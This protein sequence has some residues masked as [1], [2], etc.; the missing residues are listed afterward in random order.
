MDYRERRSHARG[1][2]PTQYTSRMG[3]VKVKQEVRADIR[4]MQESS[5]KSAWKK[6]T[7]VRRGEA[8]DKI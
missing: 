5:M 6:G 8:P 1:V 2:Y 3:T 4:I 7:W